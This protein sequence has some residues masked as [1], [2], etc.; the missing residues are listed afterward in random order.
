MGFIAAYY[1]LPYSHQKIK[2]SEHTEM[3]KKKFNP[4]WS[5]FEEISPDVDIVMI[6][7]SLTDNARWGEIF[8]KASIANRGIGRDTTQ[9]IINR[10][11]TITNT[12]PEKAFIMV[13]INDI[14][15]NI[16]LNTTK[17][18]YEFIIENLLSKNI[19]VY[20]QSTIYCNY[21]LGEKRLKKVTELNNFLR[22]LAK[23]KSLTYID[24]NKE[25][26]DKKG[27]KSEYTYDGIHLLGSGY[28]TWSKLIEPYI[29]E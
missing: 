16:D 5:Q 28:V 21:S 6:G 17:K 27:L 20:I 14:I 25:L 1:M 11:D 7:D 29:Y 4:L 18:N 23:Q 10:L 9:D 19:K 3:P 12:T 24:L 2:A 15:H 13:G 26:S 22:I 8:P